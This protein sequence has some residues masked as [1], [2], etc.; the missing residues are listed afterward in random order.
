MTL[1]NHHRHRP[2]RGVPWRALAAWLLTLCGSGLAQRTAIA[3]AEPATATARRGMVVSVSAA[4]SEVGAAILRR[5]GNAVDSAVA[6]ALALAVTYPPAGNLAGGGFMLIL[7]QPGAQPVCVEYRE[8]APAAATRDMFGP[9]ES[10][11]G[12]K[13]VGVPGTIR[14]L[15]LAHARFG[16][17]AWADVVTPARNLARDGFVIDAALAHSLNRV[18]QDPASMAFDE[19]RRVYGA[20]PGHTWVAGDRLVQPDLARTLARLADGGAAAFYEGPVAAAIVA[21][22]QAGGVL[23][24]ADLTQY[25]AHVREPVHATYRQWDVYAP[26]LPSSGGVALI[27]MLN[28]LEPFALR[29]R[30]RDSPESC[31]LMLET[32]RRAFLDR[33]RYLGDTDFIAPPSFLTCKS[34]AASLGRSIDPTRA[35]RS[36]DLA[37]DLPIVAEGDSTTHFSIIDAEGMAVA[38]TYTLEQSYGSRVM[39]RGAGFLL[40]NQMGDFNWHPGVSNVHGAIGT[41]PNVI[42]PGKRMLSSQCP[43]LVLED[44]QPFLI[45]GSPGGRTIINTVLGVVLNVLEFDLDLASAVAAPRWHHAWLPDEACFE[46]A[47]AESCRP[48][49]E[50]LR[51]LGHTIVAPDEPQGDAHS[52]R[53]DRTAGVY[54]GVADD[55]ISGCAVGVD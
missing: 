53:V 38:N 8:T 31:H 55:R 21:E 10:R 27:Q 23:T 29:T 15:T 37:T 52:I 42:E 35:S 3:A 51:L 9:G 2:S 11:L 12:V 19:L 25:A 5:G 17:L 47:D 33:A 26:P 14:G 44:G 28:V 49:V 54:L 30:G 36:T 40:N 41:R 16:R 13:T 50:R 18:L 46:D 39:V 6:T 1:D 32:M 4:A 24:A 22:M 45:T 43:V 20:P 48:L 34:Y 7:P